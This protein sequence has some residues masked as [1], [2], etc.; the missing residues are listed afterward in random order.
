MNNEKVQA[1]PETQEENK[2]FD[3]KSLENKS[4]DEQITHLDSA[5]SNLD[6]MSEGV[7]SALGESELERSGKKGVIDQS[8]LFDRAGLGLK[9]MFNGPE[10]YD[11]KLLSMAKKAA[12]NNLDNLERG[13]GSQVL[14][15]KENIKT[16]ETVAKNDLDAVKDIMKPEE[17]SAI[18]TKMDEEKEGLIFDKDQKERELQEKLSE[19]PAEQKH[20]KL[21]NLLGEY[22]QIE[23]SIRDRRS[24]L[25][26]SLKNHQ[27]AFNKIMGQ[28]ESSQ[29]IKTQL[30]EKMAILTKQCE[31]MKIRE[32][33]VKERLDSLK[34]SQKE[35]DPVIKKIRTI[36][37]TKTEI[38]EEEKARIQKSKEP[39]IKNTT[40]KQK[41]TSP[42]N[43]ENKDASAATAVSP[44]VK[45]E[46]ANNPEIQS[47]HGKRNKNQQQKQGKDP[48]N[49]PEGSEEQKES[50]KLQHVKKTVKQWGI[51]LQ[52]TSKGLLELADIKDIR[53]SFNT[54]PNFK[55]KD[56]ISGLDAANFLRVL[57]SRKMTNANE[58]ARMAIKR[59]IT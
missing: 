3:S 31:E 36:G 24:G 51:E 41:P 50:V 53:R 19:Y 49:Q 9:K 43:P 5:L 42:E 6:L 52:S 27:I 25:E 38:I 55:G 4:H 29:E 48:E 45:P 8:S 33:A 16:H 56:E 17:L 2:A 44:E 57:L 26:N 12:E 54:N 22:G 40:E 18:K 13:L 28:E 1:A 37:K 35:L 46:P 59:I 7:N 21:T 32:K 34:N 14:S 23:S 15:L 20:E 11:E 30:K 58:K 39:V 10:A 47:K